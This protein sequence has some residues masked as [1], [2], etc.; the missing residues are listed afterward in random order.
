MKRENRLT[1]SRD[2]RRT[3]SDGRRGSSELVL[4][5]VRREGDAPARVGVTTTRRFAGAVE[6]NRAK[7][8]LREAARRLVAELPSG[9]DVVLMARP[10]IRGK[11]FQEVLEDVRMAAKSAGASG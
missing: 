7:R 11:S 5:F 2:V 10:P 4:C 6:R 9:M 8:L 3:L 1:S